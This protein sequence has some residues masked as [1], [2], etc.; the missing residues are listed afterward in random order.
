MTAEQTIQ[1]TELL[2]E[3]G[4]FDKAQA[5]RFTLQIEEVIEMK[6]TSLETKIDKLDEKI[7]ARI[8]KLDERFDARIDKLDER[9]DKQ[10]ANLEKK[11]DKLERSISRLDNRLWAAFIT[12]TVLVLGLYATVLFK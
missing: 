5:N 2:Q 1:I 11:F 7:D 9:F 6:G 10:E 12:I 8:D 4:A 3:T